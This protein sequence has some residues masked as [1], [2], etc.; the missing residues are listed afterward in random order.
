VSKFDNK[1]LFV[2][3]EHAQHSGRTSPKNDRLASKNQSIDLVGREIENFI[4]T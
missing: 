3:L 1:T 4:F 2:T